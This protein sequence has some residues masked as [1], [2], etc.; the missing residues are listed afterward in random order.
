MKLAT[1]A[2]NSTVCILQ[3]TS[4]FWINCQW[5]LIWFHGKTELADLADGAEWPHGV[6]TTHAVAVGW[7]GWL[8]G[9]YRVC[10]GCV[11]A[12]LLQVEQGAGGQEGREG[13]GEGLPP[14]SSRPR[15]SGTAPLRWVHPQPPTISLSCSP[16][17]KAF[18]II[19]HLLSNNTF[20]LA[21]AWNL[22]LSSNFL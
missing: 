16:N 17:T 8:V 19:P 9:V 12:C 10:D 3:K 2:S 14:T 18:P 15:S 11:G 20:T 4:W 6:V 7:V 13:A 5:V 22:T 1:F 21:T